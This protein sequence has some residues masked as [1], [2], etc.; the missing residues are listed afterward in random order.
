MSKKLFTSEQKL[1]RPEI[2]QYIRKIADGVESGEI[3]LKS[4][5]NSIDLHLSDMPE[6]E[7]QVEQEADG[8]K[9][10]EI[11]IEWKEGETEEGLE[12]N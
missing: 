3:N 8:E 10:L 9:S 1:S 2:A 4:G 11:E 12:I 6:L 7:V 5:Q